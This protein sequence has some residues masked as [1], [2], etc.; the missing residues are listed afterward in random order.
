MSTARP[1]TRGGRRRLFRRHQRTAI[2]IATIGV[3]VVA[4]GVTWLILNPRDEDSSALTWPTTGYAAV[5]V[6]GLLEQGPGADESRP[7]GSIAKVVTAMVVLDRIPLPPGSAGPAFGLTSADF[8][9][10]QQAE[11]AGESRAPAADGDVL[12]LRTFLEYIMVASS[13]NHAR[14]LVDH[15]FGSEGAYL[16]AAREWLDSHDLQD[17][18]VADAT[19]LS[20]ETRASATELLELGKLA[21]SD[22]V[23]AEIARMT[24]MVVG[25]TPIAST[26]TLLDTLGID[27]LKTGTSNAGGHSILFTSHAQG[28][29]II[30]V[31]L[32]SPS[33]EQRSTDV[34]RLVAQ[35]VDQE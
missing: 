9:Y 15:V 2:T 27:G 16:A 1:T 33:A 19:G 13:N 14:S 8:T 21:I 28:R 17:I 26:N 31:L 18:A 4:V 7:I 11:A 23:L 30:G 29:E 3:L 10:F 20:T 6:D 12:S 5:T 32:A 34:I 22:P 35:L 24:D 25:G